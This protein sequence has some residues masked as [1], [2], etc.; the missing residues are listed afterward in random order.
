M[1][2]FKKVVLGAAM[3]LAFSGA[4]AS[5]INIDGVSWDPD[6]GDD[7]T[8]QFAFKQFFLPPVAGQNELVGFGE[9]NYL[10][11]LSAFVNTQNAF[12][13]AITFC[14]SC[15]LTF[16]FGGFKTVL[17]GT[18][19][20]FDSSAAYLNIYVDSA[21][22]YDTL[23]AGAPNANY[24]NATNGDLWLSL[25]A[26]SNVFNSQTNSYSSGTL[27]V[28]WSVIQTP[29][30]AW[31]NFNTDGQFGSDLWQ[32]ATAALNLGTGAGQGTGTLTGNSIPEPASL[33]LVGLGLVGVSALRRRKAAK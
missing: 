1:K 6:A 15:E 33:A 18:N 31:S 13:S 5:T 28:F 14:P 3:A 19:V 2:M 30:T 20:G 4:Q 22:D 8:A 26:D 25:K 7:F 11:G 16:E 9:V 17:I 24:T 12:G 32:N 21:P 10:N 27:D 29:G 23:G